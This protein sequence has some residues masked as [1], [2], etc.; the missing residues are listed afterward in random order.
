MYDCKGIE[1]EL[2][3]IDAAPWPSDDGRSDAMDGWKCD[4]KLTMGVQRSTSSKAKHR[5]KR[6]GGGGERGKLRAAI[7]LSYC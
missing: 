7:G 6:G 1:L 4:M 3:L 2:E 5:A